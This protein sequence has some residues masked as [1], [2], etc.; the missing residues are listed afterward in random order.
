M[1]ADFGQVG[2]GA[3]ELLDRTRVLEAGIR[4]ISYR[5]RCSGLLNIPDVSR[6]LNQTRADNRHNGITG[7][8]VIDG[9]EVFQW[10]EGPVDAVEAL[11]TKISRDA[12][13]EHIG[14]LGRV[15]LPMRAFATWDMQLGHREGAFADDPALSL[16]IPAQWFDELQSRTDVAQD[17]WVRLVEMERLQHLTDF[18]T[19]VQVPSGQ[20]SGRGGRRLPFVIEEA[21]DILT[22]LVRHLMAEGES[23]GDDY[24]GA[25]QRRG[26]STETI[27]PHLFEPAARRL[28]DLWRDDLCSEL[29]V[30]FA[31]C[32]LQ[33]LVRRIGP[34]LQPRS[35]QALR[36]RCVLVACLPQEAHLLALGLSS[37]YFWQANWDVT[38]AIPGSSNEL[39]GLLR[40]RHFDVLDLSLSTSF[41]RSERLQAMSDSVQQARVASQNQALTILATGRIFSEQPGL[42]CLVGADGGYLSASNAVHVAEALIHSLP[43]RSYAHAQAV[44]L[45]VGGRVGTKAFSEQSGYKAMV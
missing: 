5:S 37:A 22:E 31:L 17:L 1:S 2:V 38:C 28:G 13:H 23:D 34:T 27:F 7:V 10:L 35:V 12:R 39:M 40:G 43:N 3:I 18:L 24:V 30:T 32:R 4:A 44:L 25:L 19:P 36:R 9:G 6:L 14:F 29:D 11:W 8:L 45:Q 21:T 20:A 15:D 42:R 41:Q 33:S 16:V 26:L